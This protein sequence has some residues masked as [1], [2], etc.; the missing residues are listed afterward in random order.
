MDPRKYISEST[1]PV[2][3]EL[4]RILPD[5]L[6]IFSGILALLTSSLS[7]LT[8]FGSLI[9]GL[10]IFHLIKFITSS[11]GATFSKPSDS[12]SSIGCKTGFM[13]PSFTDLSLFGA[14]PTNTF[15][16]APMYILSVG[17]AYLITS[18]GKQIPELQA[19]GPEFSARYYISVVMLCSLLFVVG[20]YRLYSSC[21][22]VGGMIVSILLGLLVGTLILYQNYALFG[23]DSTNMLGIPLLKDRTVN[24]EKIYVCS[25]N[26]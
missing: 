10:G 15:P 5:S 12:Y 7:N 17:A 6:I 2:L 23:P 25:V 26:P 1:V 9:E 18:L 22:S 19:L 8:F 16:S 13:T 4:V 21:E 20:C 14:D 11:L 3:G 24:G